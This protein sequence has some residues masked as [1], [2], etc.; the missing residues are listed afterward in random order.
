MSGLDILLWVIMSVFIANAILVAT[1]IFFERRNPVSTWAWIFVLSFMPVIGFIIYLLF[2]RNAYTQ[3]VFMDK[4]ENDEKTLFDYVE[5]DY[6]L[7][8]EVERQTFSNDG[9]GL[10]KEYQNLKDFV[11]LN[12]KAG[13]WLCYNNTVTHFTDGREKFNS[14]I[15]DIRSAKKFI[16]LQYYIIRWDELGEQI[17][18]ELTKKAAEG[19]KVRI[20]YD[21]MG[22][23]HLRKKFFEPF[24]L[25]G[26]EVEYFYIPMSLS[27]NCRN[28]R[29]VVVIDG[30]IGYIGGF[31]I[32]NE[33]IGKVKKFGNW[34]DTHVRFCGEVVNQLQLHFLMDWNHSSKKSK[35]SI[36]DFYFP[37]VDKDYEYLPVQIVCSGPDTQ[38]KNVKYSYFKMIT[39]AEKTIFIET[40][41]FIPEDDIL[42]ALKVAA[43]SGIDV[44][45]I[46]PGKP[47]HPFV[48]WASMSY[49][50]ELL[51]AGVKCYQ[52]ETGFIHSKTVFIDGIVASVGT[53]NMDIRSF[54]I[55]FEINSFIY[56]SKTIKML[57][58]DFFDDLKECTVITKEIYGKRGKMFKLKESI[59]RLI[60]PML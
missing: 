9:I 31:N 7:S 23:R 49:L 15:E 39:E 34:R 25:A 60:S 33:Y 59:S 29:K 11:T 6:E 57:E 14:L 52:Y 12:I 36:D 24:V 55:N 47:D 35:I 32:G 30:N 22:N 19:V 3:K 45:I 28:H 54:G 4:M 5:N 21:F 46:I 2:G 13:G 50:G 17:F 43:L 48:Y 51:E 41:Y 58:K 16:H 53:A 40:P 56:D 44:R 38:W 42:T 37:K 10:G 27:I 18:I 26:G 1:I 8:C 20:L